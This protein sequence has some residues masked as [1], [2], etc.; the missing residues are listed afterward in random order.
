MSDMC[1]SPNVSHSLWI[2]VLLTFLLCYGTV[3]LTGSRSALNIGVHFGGGAVRASRYSK[4]KMIYMYDIRDSSDNL[5]SFLRIPRSGCPNLFTSD[6][7]PIMT[8]SFE[9]TS[10]SDEALG[11]TLT[12]SLSSYTT[13]TAV[14]IL[15]P[16]GDTYSFDLWLYDDQVSKL[17]SEPTSSSEPHTT[18]EVRAPS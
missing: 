11:R 7:Q 14:E 6:I 4:H 3:T 13:L 5:W 1:S 16:E 12:F 18:I 10:D 17:S 9:W 8:D 2:N 15:F